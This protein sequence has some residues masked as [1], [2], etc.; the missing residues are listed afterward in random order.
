M[1][2]HLGG[3]EHL[4]KSSPQDS[5]KNFRASMT[6]RRRTQIK[7]KKKW[8]FRRIA[9]IIGFV[10]AFFSVMYVIGPEWGGRVRDVLLSAWA[11]VGIV[12][13]VVNGLL[14]PIAGFIPL[15]SFPIGPVQGLGDIVLLIVLVVVVVKLLRVK[16]PEVTRKIDE[17]MMQMR[18]TQ[19]ISKKAAEKSKEAPAMPAISF[20]PTAARTSTLQLSAS[21]VVNLPRQQVWD[22]LSEV[23]FVPT[24]QE[25]LESV[26]VIGQVAN[27]L[28]WEGTIRIG[29]RRF[30][31]EGTTTL[32]PPTMMEVR[33]TR[34]ALRG[35]RGILSLSEAP[36][37]T[38][39]IE[40]AEF[41]PSTMPEEYAPLVNALSSRG[42][43][44]LVDDLEHFDRLLKALSGPQEPEGPE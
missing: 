18:V 33:G 7:P 10:A 39:L 37:G 43:E 25:L 30:D 17:L 16:E 29:K 12:R 44:I 13:D 26:E 31:A 38:K 41:D 42:S 36:E 2:G 9:S 28:T 11:Y 35:F 22:A 34:G 6:Q 21:A 24:C 19:E 15:L 14:V 1:P 5:G 20:V 40:T 4:A 8:S 32:Y 3:G 27:A 23:V